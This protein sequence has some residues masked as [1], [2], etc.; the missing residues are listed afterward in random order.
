MK[1]VD[2]KAMNNEELISNYLLIKRNLFNLK[3]Q[4]SVGQLTNPHEIT[5]SKKNIARILTEM[6]ARNIDVNK[7]NLPAEKKKVKKTQSKT[8]KEA[9]KKE[10][11]AEPKQEAKAEVKQTKATVSKATTKT[12]ATAKK[13]TTK[14]ENV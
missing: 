7:I 1:K 14:K 6:R 3:L 13:T 2:Y 10:V 4:H 8:S 12:T 5:V 11:K 9:V